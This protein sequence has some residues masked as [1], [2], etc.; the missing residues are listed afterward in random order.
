MKTSPKG[1]ALIKTFE[2]LSL[3]AYLDPVGI[4]T[5][6]Y[7]HTAPWIKS[8]DWI[9]RE[10]AD[11]ILKEDLLEAEQAVARSVAV[12]LT[13][14]QFDALV[15]FTFNVGPGAFRSSTL[16]R[17]LNMANYLA[18]S[19]Q[20]PRWIYAGKITLPGLVRRRIAE[21]QLFDGVV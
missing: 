7:G 20:F 8:G 13:Q 11:E 21:R 1:V 10:E 14:N 4:W 15:S 5:I 6:G 18:A 17:L 19:A 2:G 9:Y 16:L 3:T 12:P